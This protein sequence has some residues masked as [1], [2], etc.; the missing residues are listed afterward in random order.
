[1]ENLRDSFIFHFPFSIFC[2]FYKMK[3][4]RFTILFLMVILTVTGL[5]LGQAK[6]RNTTKK[7]VKQTVKPTPTPTQATQTVE[8]KETVKTETKKNERPANEAQKANQN[9]IT[10]SSKNSINVENPVY[11]YEFAQPTFYVT[12][13]S[14][15]H[16]E[17]GK[18][19]IT[20]MK[21]DFEEPVSDPIQLS[22]AA[23]EKV[24][25]AF[26]ALK[27][28]DSKENYQDEE[29]NYAHLGELKLKIKKDGRERIAAFNWTQNKDA[30]LLMD[31]YR[32]ISNQ[33]VW[34]FDINL[35]RQN[36]PLEAP[37]LMDALDGYIRRNE[38]SDPPQM[39]PFLT[40][41][42]N[43][44][45]IPLIARNHATRLIKEI[46]KKAEKEKEKESNK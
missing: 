2:R 4:F 10:N 46:E 13:V 41:L 5:S 36:Q 19:K 34:I 23:L 8:Q 27:F 24:K 11:F 14:I 16:D 40:K 44:E 12:K 29:R 7:T 37:G 6:K 45:R 22:P 30:K 33:Y 3:S 32:R 17:T 31:E 38:I 18:G 26:E 28:L 20:F 42:S 35:A 39:I 15:E 9:S 25:T 1:M 43:D 21:K